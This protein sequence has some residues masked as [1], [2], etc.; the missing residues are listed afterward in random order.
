MDQ[1]PNHIQ[2]NAKLQE[3]IRTEIVDAVDGMYVCESF[4]VCYGH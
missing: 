2:A 1:L 4:E 3:E